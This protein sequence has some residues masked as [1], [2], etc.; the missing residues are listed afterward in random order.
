MARSADRSSPRDKATIQASK[1]A[2]DERL[3]KQAVETTERRASQKEH[4]TPWYG[5]ASRRFRQQQD[6]RWERDAKQTAARKVAANAARSLEYEKYDEYAKA[7]KLAV[8]RARV[9]AIR[10]EIKKKRAIED[11]LLAWQ[12]RPLG[13]EYLTAMESF[14]A[15]ASTQV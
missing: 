2:D 3:T 8:E 6:A 13:E 5:Y 11:A 4:D 14:Q 15:N 1:R 9:E 7:K 12:Y 10:Q